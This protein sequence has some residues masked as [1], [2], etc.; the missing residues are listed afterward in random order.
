MQYRKSF[1]IYLLIVFVFIQALSGLIGGTWLL[2]DPSGGKIG[3]PA[4]WLE[5]SPFPDYLIPGIILFTI[6]GI[7]PL[8]IAFG[9]IRDSKKAL[10]GSRLLGYAM[11]IWIGVEIMIIGYQ[12]EPPLQVI[13]GCLGVIILLLAYSSNVNNYYT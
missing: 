4:A 1:S 11:L 3:L 6:L 5:S 7:Y 12:P 13:Y 2:A 9:L 8:M 10:I